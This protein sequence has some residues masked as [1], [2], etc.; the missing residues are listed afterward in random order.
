ME[1]DV[2]KDRLVVVGGGGDGILPKKCHAGMMMVLK[3]KRADG[4]RCANCSPLEALARVKG[5][6]NKHQ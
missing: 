4:K 2:N 5:K 3:N 1:T 6:E